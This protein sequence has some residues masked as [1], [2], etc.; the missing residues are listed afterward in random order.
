MD[1]TADVIIIGGGIIGTAAGYYL[2]RKGLK[3]FLFEKDYLTAGSTGR[4]IGGIRQQ[5]STELSIKVAMESVKKFKVM[6]N[7]LQQDVE[8]HPGGYLFLA[9]DENKKQVYLELIKLQQ[10]MELDVRYVDVK[11]IER[12][13]PGINTQGLL[14]G[15]HCPSDGQANPFL[16]VDAY[17]RHI[18]HSG[19]V[20]T[21]TEVQS[22]GIKNERVDSIST[23]TGEKYYAPVVINAAGPF[24]GSIARLLNIDIPI[25]PERHEAII[26]EPIERFFDMMIVDYRDDGC[27]FNQKY[28]KGSI[29]GCYTP[30]PN[31][32]GIDLGTSFEFAKE[33]GRRMARLIPKLE[34]VKIMRQWSGSYEMTPDGNPILDQ[35]QI[36]GFWIVGGMCGH[37][38][39]LGPEI[40][41][42]AAEYILN[43]KPPYDINEF[44]LNRSFAG[45]EVMK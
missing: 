21:G 35:T 28:H 14:G 1:N 26:T 34:K 23:S 20:F 13:V 38:F 42:L 29:I 18:A 4:C 25:Y 15:A 40:G 22:I 6:A 10:E 31:V 27:Y 17:A 19:K 2:A 5:F 36:R 39:M 9:H 45:K 7:E 11:E 30:K 41:W 24:C 32:P 8:F 43:G 16:I 44:A 12:L 3:V 37:G 33:M